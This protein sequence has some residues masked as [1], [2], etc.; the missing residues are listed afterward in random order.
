[1]SVY[2]LVQQHI[3]NMHK[4]RSCSRSSSAMK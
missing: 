1:M 2:S 4:P 3:A